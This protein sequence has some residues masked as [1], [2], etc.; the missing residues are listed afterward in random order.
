MG[1]GEGK[2]KAAAHFDEGTLEVYK[3]CF[4]LM[5]I[6]KDGVINK[7]DLRAAFDNVGRLVMDDELNQML[8]EVGGPCNYDN[9]IK[10]FEAKMAGGVNDPDDLIVSAFKA[11][12]EEVEEKIKGQMV[13]RHILDCEHFKHILTTFG[14]PLNVDDMDDIFDEFD[15]DD[16]GDILT[17]SVVDLFVAG[18]MDEKKEEEE[19]KK[20]GESAEQG[21]GGEGDDGGQKKKKKKKKAAK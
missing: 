8:S 7:T 10:M 13:K 18:A 2:G 16:N 9:M 19:E 1:K 12:D 21:E 11:F 15:F 14:D 4:R 20:E 6:D 17:K 3:E 5:D